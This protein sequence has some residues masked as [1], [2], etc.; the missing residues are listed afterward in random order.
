MLYKH[1]WEEWLDNNY[2]SI[3]ALNELF[4][5]HGGRSFTLHLVDSIDIEEIAQKVFDY[6]GEEAYRKFKSYINN[7]PVDCEVF[8]INKDGVLVEGRCFA[9]YI[10]ELEPLIVYDPIRRPPV[11]DDIA[12]KDC[13]KCLGNLI[14]GEYRQ[15][16]EYERKMEEYYL[17]KDNETKLV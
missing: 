12:C 6:N 15:R 11:L 13:S 14:C 2:G 3:W 8:E 4:T 17:N 16:L 1:E 9:D 7:N 10:K 5:N